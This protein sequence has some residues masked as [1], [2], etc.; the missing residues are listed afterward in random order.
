MIADQALSIEVIDDRGRYPA[1]MSGQSRHGV[2]R[3]A[4]KQNI[5]FLKARHPR[6]PPE[7]SLAPCALRRLLPVAFVRNDC[8]TKEQTHYFDF[9]RL[10]PTT[11]RLS[12]CDVQPHF[13]RWPNGKKS[14]SFSMSMASGVGH[15]KP[16]FLLE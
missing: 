7:T 9:G 16:L 15:L 6:F 5:V 8:A 4:G 12:K 1:S 14:R 2:E 11:E 13:E 3:L 10:L